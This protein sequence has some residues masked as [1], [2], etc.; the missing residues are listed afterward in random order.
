VPHEIDVNGRS[1]RVD[2]HRAEGRFAV[3]VDGRA[4][5]V[6]ATRV[7]AHTLSLLIESPGRDGS[8]SRS[9]EV[10]LAPDAAA[11]G[12]VVGVGDTPVRVSL[13]HRRGWGRRDDG[14]QAG[15][16][17]QRIVAPM[18]GRIARILVKKGEPVQPRQPIIV[19]EAMKME[20]ELRAAA[21]G[22]LAEIHVQ[23]GQSVE[24]GALLAVVHPR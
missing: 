20:N 22:T 8:T 18:P 11:G 14:T 3:S 15:D 17:P 6:D 23:D 21:D 4:W 5:T 19:I 1:R 16:G 2:I 7:N 10:S 9:Y 24:A 13:N 12:L